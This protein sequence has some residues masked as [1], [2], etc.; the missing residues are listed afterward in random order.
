MNGWRFIHAVI[1]LLPSAAGCDKNS[2]PHCLVGRLDHRVVHE[3]SAVIDSRQ[4]PGVFWTV[5]DS[6]NPADLFAFRR[7]GTLLGRF[8]VDATNTD[9]ESLSADDEGHLF[10]GDTGNNDRDREM[11][12]VYKV[13]EP[14]PTVRRGRRPRVPVL[15]SWRLTYPDKPFDAE[16]LVINGDTG[17]VIAKHHG[18]GAGLYSFSLAP[19][20]YG[21]QVLHYVG[22]LPIHVPVTDAA[23]S[24]DK[25][26]L[27]IQTGD[28]PYVFSGLG[29]NMEKACRI[30]PR[31]VVCEGLEG[32]NVEG[33]CFVPEGLLGTTEQGHIL[34]FELKP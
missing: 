1:L 2:G 16:S 32:L 31:H 10:I 5:C 34:L 22:D 23:L 26:R 7:D 14:D 17:Y 11:I 3:G 6:G 13:D 24:H 18:K 12:V 15:E 21:P 19:Q 30:R 9:W 8:P 28:G 4:H 25:D 29:G 33:V 20:P 27:A